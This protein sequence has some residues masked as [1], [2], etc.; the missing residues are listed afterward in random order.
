M[1]IAY[2]PQMPQQVVPWTGSFGCDNWPSPSL[3]QKRLQEYIVQAA[4]NGWQLQ[5]ANTAQATFIR[6]KPTNHIL[7]AILTIFLLGFWIIP[8]IAIA[9]TN[10]VEQLVVTIDAY[11]LMHQSHSIL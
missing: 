2:R 1:T 4:R 5:H 11:G 10:Q 9:A 3:A 7:H 8:W 6:G